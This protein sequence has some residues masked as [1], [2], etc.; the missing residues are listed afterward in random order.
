M[1]TYR[2]KRKTGVQ[3]EKAALDYDDHLATEW[4]QTSSQMAEANYEQRLEQ[5]KPN[6]GL[7]RLRSKQGITQDEIAEVCGINK[8]SYQNYESG[9]QAIPST[10]LAK[11]SAKYLVDIHG[12]F[13]GAPHSNNLQ[14]LSEVALFTA[15]IISCLEAKFPSMPMG[16]KKFIAMEFVGK[17]RLG[18][19]VDIDN[20]FDSIRI[21]TGDK[22]L[23]YD[24]LN[25]DKMNTDYEGSESDD[26]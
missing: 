5:M 19:R 8:R 21:V 3:K 6:E 25:A 24:F 17:N 1:S 13:T 10:V 23:T 26:T 11:L 12:L 4:Q 16:E 20:L 9:R 18:T 15:E 2:F 7:R 14:T 22:Y